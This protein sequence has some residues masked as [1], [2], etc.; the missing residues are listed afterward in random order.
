[1]QSHP[2]QKRFCLCKVVCQWELVQVKASPY[3]SEARE[4]GNDK[5]KTKVALQGSSA[6]HRYISVFCLEYV[7]LSLSKIFARAMNDGSC[8]ILQAVAY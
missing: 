8:F 5:N 6:L 4:K 3:D 1:M 7:Q 2:F